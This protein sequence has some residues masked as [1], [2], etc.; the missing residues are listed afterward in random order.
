MFNLFKKKP[1]DVDL[2]IVTLNYFPK[3]VD[4]NKLIFYT[5]TSTK[6]DCEEYINKRLFVENREH[7]ESWCGLRGYDFKDMSKWKEYLTGGTVDLRKYIISKVTYKVKDIATIFRMF[8]NCTPLG[9]SYDNENEIMRFIE[10]LMAEMPEEIEKMK[11]GEE[12]KETLV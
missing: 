3:D 8:N 7:Y 2:Y 1:K 6:E 9:T 12:I 5:I 10:Q 11:N 4:I